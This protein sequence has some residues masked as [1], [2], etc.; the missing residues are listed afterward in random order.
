MM[1]VN[2]TETCIA[3]LRGMLAVCGLC[4]TE[5]AAIR[6]AID[7]M[8]G[9]ETDRMDELYGNNSLVGYQQRESPPEKEEREKGLI[10]VITDKLRKWVHKN[11]TVH[12]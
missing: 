5:K 9:D 6:Y 1:Q 4:E 2:D 12:S 10:E 8:E 7:Q 11:D 3:V